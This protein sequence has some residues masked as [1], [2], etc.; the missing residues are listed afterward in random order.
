MRKDGTRFWA[1]V[2]ITALRDG[3]GAA[4]RLRQGH[5]RP[6]RAAPP[7]GIAA[8]ERRAL[9]RAGRK[10]AGLRHLHARSG[11]PRRHLERRRAAHQGIQRRGDHRRALLRASIRPRPRARLAAA[12]AADRRRARAASRTRAG[13][14]ARTASRFWANVVIT[15]LRDDD[16]TLLGFSKITRDLTERR[17]HEAASARRARSAS[18]CWSRACRTTRSSCSTPTGIDHQ[19]EHRRRAHQGLR[20]RARS[21]AGTS[22]GSIRPRTSR[23]GKPW[24]ELAMARDRGRVEDEGWRVRK[25]GTRFWANV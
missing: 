25:D 24:R 18:A 13:A 17:E 10:R 8:P 9:S 1:N 7:R 20:R 4:D 12:R 23:A 22:R 16:G 14:C 15:A 2:V 6:H 11:R 21:S 3:D 19:L 5:A